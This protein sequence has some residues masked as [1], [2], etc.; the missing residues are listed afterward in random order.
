MTDKELQN[1]SQASYNWL[2]SNLQFYRMGE[3]TIEVETPLI[4][5]FGQKVY[6]FIEGLDNGYRVSDDGWLMYKLDP[7]QEDEDFY[8]AA[9]DVAVGSGFDFDEE[10]NEIFQD[11]EEKELPLMLNNL[12]QLEVAI[13]YLR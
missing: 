5:A 11:V 10:I 6:C 9:V 3:S 13:S 1:I 12:A 7:N 2:K 4:D 8:E